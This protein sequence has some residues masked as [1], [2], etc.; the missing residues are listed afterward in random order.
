MCIPCDVTTVQFLP[1][2]YARH[3]YERKRTEPFIF[4]TYTVCM[5]AVTL[6]KWPVMFSCLFCVLPGSFLFHALACTPSCCLSYGQWYCLPSN[7]C[8]TGHAT[9]TNSVCCILLC[10]K[11]FQMSGDDIVCPSEWCCI[12]HGVGSG[13]VTTTTWH[14]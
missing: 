6:F 1:P 12:Q 7:F 9:L 14:Y 4:G 3:S 8:L 2:I 11:A 10:Y 5:P 13:E